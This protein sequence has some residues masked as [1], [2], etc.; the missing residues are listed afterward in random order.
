MNWYKEYQAEWKEIIDCSKV[1]TIYPKKLAT[2]L[3][4]SG[5]FSQVMI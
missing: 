1:N 5:E 2:A 3:I 4:G